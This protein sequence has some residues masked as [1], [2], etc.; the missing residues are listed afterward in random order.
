MK[1]TR[2]MTLAGIA[3]LPLA[4]CVSRPA[5]SA[6][7]DALP[8]EGLLSPSGASWSHLEWAR[9]FDGQRRSDLG[10]GTFLNPVFSGDRPDPTVLRD[11][12]IYYMTFSS[13]DA[14]PGLV[15]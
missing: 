10:D 5:N 12:D 3:G 15:I 14:Y 13:F 1:L 7:I 6:S 2:R 9:G 4:A 11:G 8:Q